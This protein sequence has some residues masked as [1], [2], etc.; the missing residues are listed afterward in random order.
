LSADREDP[1]ADEADATP[2]IV[3]NADLSEGVIES[4][5]IGDPQRSR[6]WLVDAARDFS[7]PEFDWFYVY[8]TTRP[9]KFWS[10]GNLVLDAKEPAVT[11]F[12]PG[13]EHTARLQEPAFVFGVSSPSTEADPSE[14][15]RTARVA[16]IEEALKELGGRPL[17]LVV[18]RKL[19]DEEDWEDRDWSLDEKGGVPTRQVLVN[20]ADLFQLYAAGQSTRKSAHRH[21]RTFEA[22]ASASDIQ[23]FWKGKKEMF[24]AVKGPAVVVFSP[25]VCHA[26]SCSTTTFIFQVSA[27]GYAIGDD[28][29]PC[30][31]SD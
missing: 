1:R 8:A 28:G 9:A 29:A 4:I 23:V 13:I 20:K 19:R 26:T 18:G 22:F 31:I 6:A 5:P 3:S 16:S 30:K 7:P 10:K 25:N 17:R 27:D 2:V 15:P 24:Q 21:L 14:W 11:V 12:P